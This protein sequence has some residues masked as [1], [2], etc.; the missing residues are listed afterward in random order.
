MDR[1]KNKFKDLKANKEKALVGFISAGDP[2]LL[3]SLDLIIAMC[4]AGLDVL[5]LGIAFSDPVSDGPVI[6]RSCARALAK[7]IN[8][9]KVFDMTMFFSFFLA[10]DGF[11]STL[12]YY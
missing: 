5:E 8:L 9:S 10:C 1:I 6:Q 2:D 11:C 12:I 7:G 3:K 4:K